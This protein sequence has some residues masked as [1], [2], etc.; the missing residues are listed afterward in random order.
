MIKVGDVLR[1]R[2][3]IPLIPMEYFNSVAVV[4]KFHKWVENDCVEVRVQRNDMSHNTL[5]IL[6]E[7]LI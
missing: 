3:G 4:T 2:K 1:I 7:D 6:K 5:Y